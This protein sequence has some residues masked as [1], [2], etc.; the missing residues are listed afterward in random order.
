MGSLLKTFSKN[1]FLPLGLFFVS[2]AWNDV[3]A[4]NL[5]VIYPNLREPYNR[6]FESIIGGIEIQTSVKV[7]RYTL[8]KEYDHKRLALRI[9]ENNNQLIFALG[10]KGL[11]AIQRMALDLPVVIGAVLPSSIH[12]DIMS[13]PGIT[14]APCPE[15][16]FKQL[17][18]FAPTIK[19]VSVVYNPEINQ[20]L[21]KEAMV[22]AKRLGLDINARQAH[23]LR[24]AAL[25]YRDLMK[26]MDDETS[27]IWLLQDVTTIDSD[28]IL[29]LL[30]EEA[31]NRRLI[32]FSS[33]LVHVKKGVL[34]SMYPDNLKLGEELGKLAIEVMQNKTKSE[35]LS[36]KALKLAVNIRIAKHL[37]IKIQ[38]QQE[39][40]FDLIFPRR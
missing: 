12:S 39:K 37:G 21:I 17:K 15:M 31:W 36:L 24:S 32:V 7:D 26:E 34:F 8:E 18:S 35:L 30:L 38:R 33:N 14:L 22:A 23:D 5:G 29:P 27:A 19:Q 16:L 4:A 10:L 6:I 40:S 2:F 9:K 20:F 11:E 25:I 28:T 1:F 3:T 13:R